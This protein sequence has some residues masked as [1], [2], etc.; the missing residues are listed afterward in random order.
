MINGT[1]AI[2]EEAALQLPEAVATDTEDSSDE[3]PVGEVTDINSY[4]GN[5]AEEAPGDCE[6]ELNE[7]TTRELARSSRNRRP[8]RYWRD[9][10][11]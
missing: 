6:D 3:E 8:P 5:E 2:Y 9:Y 1:S 4:S 7:D 11:V 10:Y